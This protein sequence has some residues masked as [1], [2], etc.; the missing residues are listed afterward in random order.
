MDFDVFAKIMGLFWTLA[1]GSILLGLR[2]IHLKIRLGSGSQPWALA[3]GAALFITLSCFMFRGE[4][5]A[6][7]WF[8]IRRPVD[9]NF[10]QHARWS[11]FCAVWVLLEGL[12]MIYCLRLHQALKAILA[13]NLPAPE[14]L[15]GPAAG[16]AL[17]MLT[18]VLFL[19]YLY[20]FWGAV[21]RLGLQ[22]GHIHRI[23]FFYIRVCGVFWILFEWVV[24]LTGLAAWR[25]IK[26]VEG[27]AA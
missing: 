12:I 9:L 23:A 26:K 21:Q 24:A 8:A 3:L 14:G 4:P 13:G 17:A 25:L 22:P 10:L 19:G 11:F 1:E 20:F 2:R 7:S 5:W 18:A 27:G 15:P 6:A 16:P